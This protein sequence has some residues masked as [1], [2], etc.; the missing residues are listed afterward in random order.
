MAPQL[1][2]LLTSSG[3]I[4]HADRGKEKCDLEVEDEVYAEWENQ[5]QC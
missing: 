2:S 1:S 4:Y 5:I 3:V